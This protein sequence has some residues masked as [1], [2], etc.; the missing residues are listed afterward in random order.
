MKA[1]RCNL[2][3]ELIRRVQ[4]AHFER[5][6]GRPATET[7]LDLITL[8]RSRVVPE[9][10]RE[11]RALLEELV[12]AYEQRHPGIPGGAFG[13]NL[14]ELAFEALHLGLET[15]LVGKAARAVK[16]VPAEEGEQAERA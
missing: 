6:F 4:A 12:A 11:F 16:A 15:G 7:D 3:P 5:T 1:P 9:R 10:L 2:R 8:F 14:R 13:R